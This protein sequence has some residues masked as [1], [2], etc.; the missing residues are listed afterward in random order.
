M[1]PFVIAQCPMMYGIILLGSFTSSFCAAC[2]IT[3]VHLRFLK[4]LVGWPSARGPTLFCSLEVLPTGLVR[5]C[6]LCNRYANYWLHSNLCTCYIGTCCSYYK[7]ASI[8]S[9]MIMQQ[10]P[11][12]VLWVCCSTTNS[13]CSPSLSSVLLSLI[14]DFAQLYEDDV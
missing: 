1:M 13:E 6:N 5:N 3:V 14:P 7:P 4:L 12:R 10:G 11:A 2:F 9:C 8:K